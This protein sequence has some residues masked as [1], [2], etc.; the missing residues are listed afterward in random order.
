M[1]YSRKYVKFFGLCN[2][3]HLRKL[4]WNQMLNMKHMVEM[5]GKRILK[6]QRVVISALWDPILMSS[7]NPL[8]EH[9]IT[10]QM[11]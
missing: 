11:A 9:I 6:S 7:L 2:L 3:D 1:K 4:F 8:F 5:L 10:A